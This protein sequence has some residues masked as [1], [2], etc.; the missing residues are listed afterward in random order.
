MSIHQDQT[1]ES[2]PKKKLDAAKLIIWLL[3]GCLVLVGY[4][5]VHKPISV[6]RVTVVGRSVLDLVAAAGLTLLAGGI[7]RR[8]LQSE[9]WHPLESLALQA[10]L[11]WG[12]LG[13]VWFAAGL[14]GLYQAAVAWLALLLGLTIFRSDCVIWAKQLQSLVKVWQA[15]GRLGKLLVV[16]VVALLVGQLLFALAPPLKWDTLVYHLELP[17]QYLQQGRFVLVE[18]NPFWGHP[19]LGEMLY[20]WAAALRGWET[21]VVLGWSFMLVLLLGLA[22]MCVRRASST[23]GLVAV[24]A[25]MVGLSFR[26]MLAWGY[27]DGLVALYG[28]ATLGMLLE[29]SAEGDSSYKWAAGFSALAL[30]AKYTAGVLLLPLFLVVLFGKRRS[31]ARLVVQVGVIVL[32]VFMPW[33]LKNLLATGN[34]LSP[35]FWPTRYVSQSQ[36]DYYLDAGESGWNWQN[37]WFPLAVTWLGVEGAPGYAADV[38]P[39]LL[40]F[41]VPGLL[42]V[43]RKGSGRIVLVFTVTGWL[44][45]VVG[46]LFS[47][48]LI[49]TRLYFSLLPAAAL[50]A[51]WGWQVQS[52]I[53]F[54][55]V[56]L[57]RLMGVLVVL[58][59]GLCLWQDAVALV[60][61]NPAGV[62]MGARL[63]ETY[64]DDSLG[65]YA[66]VMRE[67]EELPAG[68]RVLFLWEPR[69]LYAPLEVQP[70]YW[71]DRWYLARENLGDPATILHAWQRDNYTHLLFYRFGANYKRP[72][73][74]EH[75]AADWQALDDLLGSLPQLADYDG[76]YELYSLNGEKP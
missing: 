7:G 5:Y 2:K 24:T 57:R 47:A 14:V 75:D 12:I 44:A 3:W 56:R 50:A 23:A 31:G 29:T 8:I 72:L 49:Q 61:R 67:L 38:G 20:T 48:F 66:L 58:V 46:G 4:Y 35:H 74:S 33:L 52:S 9:H 65:W 6:S 10:A 53:R 45:I 15:T 19:Q 28:F 41:A 64:L 18:D 22:G 63:P 32:L 27:V 43:W 30:G 42:S 39:L 51:A 54:F 13:F 1:H 37:A 60:R 26:Q 59:L 21:A 25:L 68:S 76:V 70:D 69:G 62:I 17:K 34:P 11:G 40:L 71:L 73:R 55:Q 36:L 16:G